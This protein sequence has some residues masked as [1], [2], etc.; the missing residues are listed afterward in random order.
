MTAYLLDVNAL[1]A[2]VDPTHVR[3]DRAHE[4]FAE[5]GSQDWLSCPTTQNGL[6]RIVSHP[7]Y[8]NAVATPAD[9]L[10]VLASLVSVGGHRFVPD[11][12]SLLDPEHFLPDRLLASGQLTDTYLLALA[13]SEGAQLATFDRRLVATGVPDGQAFA[14]LI[15]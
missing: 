4:W 14:T 10:R 2:L 7:R 9:A 11:R 8:S 6:V 15:S 13:R 12:L 1:I 5:E 3:H